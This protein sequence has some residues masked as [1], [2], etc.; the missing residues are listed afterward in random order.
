MRRFDISFTLPCSF[1]LPYAQSLSLVVGEAAQRRTVDFSTLRASTRTIRL[2]VSVL[3]AASVK[4]LLCSI[5]TAQTM[6]TVVDWS[7]LNQSD[8]HLVHFQNCP[9]GVLANLHWRQD[10]AS[11]RPGIVPILGQAFRIDGRNWLVTPEAW[12]I[13][14]VQ[15]NAIWRPT[16][17]VPLSQPA[18]V[19]L[20][21]LTQE[22]PNIPA[23]DTRD[24]LKR[25]GEYTLVSGT[26][27]SVAKVGKRW[28]LN[29]GDDYRTDFTLSIQ[30]MALA[31]FADHLRSPARLEGA[32]VIVG[33]ILDR[34]NGPFI[35]LNNGWQLTVVPTTTNLTDD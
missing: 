24:L 10:T 18:Q 26:I 4:V 22:K 30:G 2:I 16:L 19:R 6:C 25:V 14:Q 15:Q 11:E 32:Q 20:H 23:T 35:E 9:A 5:A 17:D 29:F 12:V 13:E 33:G 28:F 34:Y 7:P 21:A 8:E 3:A 1:T 27:Q 31:Q